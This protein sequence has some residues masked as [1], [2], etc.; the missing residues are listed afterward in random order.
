MRLGILSDIH[1]N[2]PAL[3]QALQRMGP[4]DELLCAG[5]ACYQFRFSNAVAARL[6]EIGARYV[7]GNHEDILLSPAGIRAQ[8]SPQVDRDLLEWTRAQPHHYRTQV[9]GKKLLL[10]H[11][12]P[13]EPYRDY[14]YPSSPELN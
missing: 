10:F 12:T 7:L 2:L 3:D 9:N 11:S 6:K 14:L 1:C 4:V 8:E 5:D 13:W